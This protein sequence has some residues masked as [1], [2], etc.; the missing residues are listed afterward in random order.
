V[1]DDFVIVFMSHLILVSEMSVPNADGR[2]KFLFLSV[3]RNSCHTKTSNINLTV[4][5]V[6][7]HKYLALTTK[8]ASGGGPDFVLFMI[9]LYVS[10]INEIQRTSTGVFCF[11]FK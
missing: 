6:K 10:K 11:L 2:I 3:L 5:S 8:W 7:A 4:F 9:V 1:V